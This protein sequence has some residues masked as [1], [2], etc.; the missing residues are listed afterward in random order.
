MNEVIC[1]NCHEEFSLDESGSAAI[2]KQVRDQQFDEELTA[3]LALAEREKESA[4]QLVELTNKNL[5]Q[6]QLSTKELEFAKDF[7]KNELILADK[8][9][10]KDAEI[11]RLQAKISVT[12]VEQKLAITN[13]IQ[14]VEKERDQLVNVL[15]TKDLEKEHLESSL[16]HAHLQELQQKEEL[17]R[18][19]DDEI[20]RV[21]DMKL[22]LSIKMIGETLEQHCEIEFNKVRAGAFLNAS[23]EKDNDAKSGSKGDYIYRE[24]DADGNEII[25]I[26][27]DM[28]N[29]G[30]GGVNKKKNEDFFKQLDKNRV[31]KNCE[32]AILV[33]MLESESELYNSGIVDVFYKEKKMYV[34]RPQ[35][36][37]PII[38]LLRNAAMNSMKYK[39]ELARVNSQSIDVSNFESKI[40]AFKE[41]FARNY[42][43]AS[44]KFK[45]A[46]DSIDKTIKE[47]EKTK[48]SLLNSEYQLRLANDKTED[49]TI[50]KLTHNNPTMK[51]RFNE[52]G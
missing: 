22:K 51:A 38:T 5:L 40:T 44:K 25:S 8:L 18:Y 37:V 2:L 4:I 24:Q 31:E 19:K 43:L 42:G 30:E 14:Q 20:A 16:K 13:A 39:A 46:I 7:A 27:F 45:E 32:Y 17:I 9:K 6:E 33:S 49:L 12:E 47:L 36:F 34:V 10:D 35:F 50:K 26:M 29:E 28:K 52:L 21:K 3:R 1:P 23:F 15:T 41:G 48:E 11:A